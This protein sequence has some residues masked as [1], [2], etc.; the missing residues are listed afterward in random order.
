[1][2]GHLMP[3]TPIIRLT[4]RLDT[5]TVPAAWREAMAVL[6]RNPA[7]PVVVDAAAVDYCDGAGV[8][9]LLRLLS[10]N[11][12]GGAAVTLQG[13][14]PQYQALLNQFKA[15]DY[16]ELA[17]LKGRVKGESLPARV[18]RITDAI[19]RDLREMVEFT[20]ECLAACG[21]V[22]VRPN[23]V[24]WGD[25]LCIA[26]EAGVNAVPIVVLLSWLLGVILAFQSAIPM[27]MFGA[28]LYVANL[29]G[30]AVLRELGP[31][32]TAIIFSGRTGAAFAAEIG[33]MKVN[34]EIDALETMGLDPVRFLVVPRLLAAVAVMPLLAIISDLVC[35]A[36]G[37]M[38]MSA[39]NVPV[40]TYV[41]QIVG[42]V[43][44]QDFVGGI[45]KSVVFGLLIAGT[46]C[47]RGL[48]TK[49]G[50]SAVGQS[51]TRAVVTSIT[52]IVIADGL[53]AVL[54]YQLGL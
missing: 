6:R 13:L 44:P 17:G 15:D 24:R 52:L 22:V 18:G 31:I 11:R 30:M 25:V 8:A 54:S 51:T 42:F 37:A 14:P 5:Q 9:L 16:R 3:E 2:L 34:E 21:R 43:H 35:L 46:G 41:N 33:T 4:G 7:A 53:F 1:M 40:T 20:G 50:A 48:Q 32:M 47:L 10:H 28:E 19:W 27:K 36:G 45:A 26:E 49:S 23:R 12:P 38:V 39:M 29:L